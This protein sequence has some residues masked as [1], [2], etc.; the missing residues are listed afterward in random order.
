[1]TQTTIVFCT[2]SGP[3][4]IKARV[5]ETPREQERGLQPFRIAEREGMIFLSDKWPQQ[6]TISM[7]Q[8]SVPYPLAMIWVGEDSRVSFI[9]IVMPGDRRTYSHRGVACV[10]LNAGV[11]ESYGIERGTVVGDA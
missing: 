4:A 10:E 2:R 1:M 6:E 11:V 3:L 5:P 9:E 8:A 7:W